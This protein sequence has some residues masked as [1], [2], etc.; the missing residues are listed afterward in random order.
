MAKN[1]AS[2]IGKRN[3]RKG[4]RF[5]LEVINKLKE[6]GYIDCVSSRSKD[7][8]A[9]ANKIDVISD[10]LPV[11]IQCKY[12]KN[13]PNYFGIEE[14]CSDKSKPFTIIWKKT[15]DSGKNSPG[16][17]AMIPFNY[18][19]ELLNRLRDVKY[20]N[21]NIIKHDQQYSCNK[22]TKEQSQPINT[23]VPRRVLSRGAINKSP[24]KE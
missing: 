12:S 5:E 19:L 15:G 18:F 1:D 13:T 8:L 17:L 14:A 11:L 20:T 2:T 23:K 7:K 10:S 4:N 22:T 6:I 21:K 16:T 3:K 24:K 9:D